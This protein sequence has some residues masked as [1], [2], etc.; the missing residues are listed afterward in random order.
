MPLGNI[1]DNGCSTTATGIEVIGR[2]AVCNREDRLASAM[3]AL[4]L[5]MRTLEAKVHLLFDRMTESNQLQ[6]QQAA[7]TKKLVER[8]DRQ[9]DAV[10]TNTVSVNSSTACSEKATTAVQENTKAVTD[11]SRAARESARDFREALG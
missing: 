1:E 11:N 9:I 10:D 3:E 5:Q 6:S 8:I 7:L 2:R 4:Q